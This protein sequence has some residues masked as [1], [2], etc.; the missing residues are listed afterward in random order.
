MSRLTDDIGKKLPKKCVEQCIVVWEVVCSI[1]TVC[2][3]PGL[4]ARPDVNEFHTVCE[5]TVN[6]SP[7]CLTLMAGLFQNEQEVGSV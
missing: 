4:P 1:T 5:R 7:Q 3:V 2:C 6:L